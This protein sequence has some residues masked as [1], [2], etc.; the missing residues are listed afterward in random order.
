M[1]RLAFFD[2]D[3]TLYRYQ[4]PVSSEVQRGLLALEA[5]GVKVALISGRSLDYVYGFSQSL[6]LRSPALMGENGL[7]LTDLELGLCNVPLR[8]CPE[9]FRLMMRDLYEAFPA[10]LD[11]QPDRV[12]LSIRPT[13]EQYP[14]VKEIVER[15]FDA[16]N[17]DFLDK[18]SF[19]FL[20]P[21]GSDKGTCAL[22]YCAKRGVLRDEVIAA[23]D[24]KNDL[25]LQKAAAQMIAVGDSIPAD[26]PNL[27]R[28]DTPEEMIRMALDLVS[29]VEKG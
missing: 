11:L 26:I 13:K 16:E 12:S 14:R 15:H 22:D 7:L 27:L 17:A 8:P 6:G 5:Q 24:S 19:L 9:C 20:A 23:G 10:G 21:K 28:A 2:I 29:R 25:P 18:N 4:T 1:F 3:G